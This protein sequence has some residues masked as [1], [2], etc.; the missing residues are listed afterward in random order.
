M[1]KFAALPEL[2]ARAT[3]LVQ[4]RPIKEVVAGALA[5]ISLEAGLAGAIIESRTDNQSVAVEC[6]INCEVAQ[7][8]SLQLPSSTTS[9]PETT[10]PPTTTSTT[11]PPTTTTLPPSPDTFHAAALPEAVP[12]YLFPPDEV[13]RLP[14]LDG[15]VAQNKLDAAT[16]EAQKAHIEWLKQNTPFVTIDQYDQFVAN[17]DNRTYV[18]AFKEHPF[19]GTTITAHCL[20]LHWAGRKYSSVWEMR[21]SMLQATSPDG[22]PDRRNTHF[23][24]NA[25][26]LD[27]TTPL[28]R[29]FKGA[30]APGANNDCLGLEQNNITSV[31]DY[32]P[33]DIQDLVM[34]M[35]YI[36]R[37]RHWPINQ[38][39]NLSHYVVDLL[40]NNAGYNPVSGQFSPEGGVRKLDIP[41][42]LRV[43]MLLHWAVKLNAEIDA[44]A[45]DT[46][47]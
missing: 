31:M 44:A 8:I 25:H 17:V 1:R 43:G 6:A 38:Y 37:Q 36:N 32:Q 9:T 41:E 35:V 14:W 5:M 2:A 47:R 12:S 40:G 19:F 23:I 18:D 30:H 13:N 33:E 28:N 10:L 42:D 15:L 27:Q 24:L 21:D 29:D 22:R 16:A 3:E 39:T 46:G 7:P 20:V 45:L 11:M 26:T 34:S 4:A